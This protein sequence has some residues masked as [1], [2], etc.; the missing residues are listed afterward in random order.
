MYKVQYNVLICAV[1]VPMLYLELRS[2]IPLMKVPVFAFD[3]EL[4]RQ[5]ALVY[6]F[7]ALFPVPLML[8]SVGSWV[9][10]LERLWTVSQSYELSRPASSTI[11]HRWM[12]IHRPCLPASNRGARW[13]TCP[14]TSRRC[15]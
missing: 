15:A 4:D 7:L 8:A 13:P 14:G 2:G 6:V 10:V 5:L 12:S 3:L 11:T 9:R 1:P